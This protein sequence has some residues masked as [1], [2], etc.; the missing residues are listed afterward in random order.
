[1]RRRN[2]A[3]SSSGIS[4]WKGRMSVSTVVLMRTSVVGAGEC[5]DLLSGRGPHRHYACPSVLSNNCRQIE[6]AAPSPPGED[7]A[8]RLGYPAR[9]RGEVAEWLKA[10]PC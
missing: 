6:T 2:S 10:A 9:T 1:M 8:Q 5:D 4:T 7:A 3:S